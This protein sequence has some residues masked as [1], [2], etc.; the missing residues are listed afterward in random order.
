LVVE[1]NRQGQILLAN[2]PI[3]KEQLVQQMRTYLGQNPK[4]AV[5]LNAD[6]KLPYDQ[7]VQLLSEMRDVGGDRVSLAI[8]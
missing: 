5:L 4:G 2:Q 7:V 1:F 3:G 6:P 8:Q